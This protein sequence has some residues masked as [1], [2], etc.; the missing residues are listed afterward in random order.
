A[1][2]ASDAGAA[3]DDVVLG[4][5][6]TT[7]GAAEG[8]AGGAGTH[9]VRR[10][11]AEETAGGV[12]DVTPGG[13]A[14]GADAEHGTPLDDVHVGPEE[15]ETPGTPG[16][17]AREIDGVVQKDASAGLEIDLAAEAAA[18]RKGA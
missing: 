16:R 5:Y 8:A 12:G 4:L 11:E 14:A 18:A 6:L 9:V 1:G 7:R 3:D 15:R 17:T 10:L 2:G 13:L